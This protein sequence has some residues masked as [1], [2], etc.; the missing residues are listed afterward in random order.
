MADQ[1]AQ[2]IPIEDTSSNDAA[3]MRREL[4]KLRGDLRDSA[5]QWAASI[6]SADALASQL[7]DVRGYLQSERERWERVIKAQDT[8]I[9]GLCALR[10]ATGG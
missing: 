8:V 10:E 6:E 1:D 4:R 7:R 9:R 3:A 2:P 5:M